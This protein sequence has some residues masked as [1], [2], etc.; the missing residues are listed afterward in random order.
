MWLSSEKQI[1]ECVDYLKQTEDVCYD[2]ESSGLHIINDY[3]IMF[4]LS[5]G[6]ERFGA[7]A[8]VMQHP[9]MKNYLENMPNVIGSNILI[10]VH[11]AANVGIN[12]KGNLINTVTMDWLYNELREGR[13]GLKDC[14]WDYCGIKMR[15]FTEVFPMKRAT[16]TTSAD[17]AKDAILRKISTEEGFEDAKQYSGLDAYA[18]A[19][20]FFFLREKLKEIDCFAPRDGKRWTLWDHFQLV[21]VPFTKLLWKLERRGLQIS[22]GY[23]K[24][25]EKKA[26]KELKKLEIELTK[27]AGKPINPRSVNQLREYF[28]RHKKYTPKKFTESA[29]GRNESVDIEVLKDLAH[30]GDG[31]A[32]ILLEH[33]AISKQLST[34][35]KGLPEAADNNGRIHSTLRGHTTS[36]RLS[37]N[38]PNLQNISAGERDI[39]K[40]RGGFIAPPNQVLLDVDYAQLELMILAHKSGDEKMLEAVN[41]EKDLHLF[42]VSL[43][44][45]YDYDECKKIKKKEGEIGYPNLTTSE[46]KIIDTRRSIKRVWYGVAYGIGADLLGKNLTSDFRAADPESKSKRCAYCGTI[47]PVDWKNSCEH[48]QGIPVY[49][50]WTD[51]RQFK[52]KTKLALYLKSVKER[53]GKILD[54]HVE[55]LEEIP[56][57]VSPVEAQQYI[58]MLLEAFPKVKEYLDNQVRIVN[59]FKC[60]QS[61]LGRYRRLPEVDSISY[62]DKLQAE[63]RSKNSIQNDAAD[64]MKIAMLAIDQDKELEKLGVELLLQIHDELIF[65]CPENDQTISR[66]KNIIQHHMEKSF[67]ERVFPLLVNLKAEPK[68]GYDW[69]SVH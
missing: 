33:R 49:N 39:F 9:Y 51:T 30:E 27:I 68:T 3:P 64:I 57:T 8:D 66:A 47:Y 12:F 37:S 41:T 63:R 23:F 67:N 61:L 7:M 22:P 52:S 55:E 45:N 24:Q 44:Y 26:D 29:S 48:I 50:E 2:T 11:W 59:Q 36:G 21:E 40:I 38:D 56:R 19:H 60:V 54:R 31:V 15:E 4:S 34:Y 65:S 18:N 62:Q 14:A 6:K 43:I 42:A 35:I 69:A 16:K 5:D 32:Q 1:I 46:K 20:V 13:H 58:D 10:D 53:Y 25:L 28:F 17:T